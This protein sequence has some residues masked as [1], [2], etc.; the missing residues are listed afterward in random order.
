MSAMGLR[1][2][3]DDSP[4]SRVR[5]HDARSRD[6][7]LSDPRSIDPVVKPSTSRKGGPH[8]NDTEKSRQGHRH[9]TSNESSKA[10][11][12]TSSS[13]ER[14]QDRNNRDRDP[15][16]KY[17]GL[18]PLRSE[19]SLPYRDQPR[20]H[21]LEDE[22][23]LQAAGA[24]SLVLADRASTASDHSR[25]TG[26]DHRTNIEPNDSISV[27]IQGG[28]PPPGNP[29]ESLFPVEETHENIDPKRAC[30]QK[31]LREISATY[32]RHKE[33]ISRIW[34]E[35]MRSLEEKQRMQREEEVLLEREW[36][37]TADRTGYS[38]C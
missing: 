23:F 20:S 36:I 26:G 24:S 12:G 35:P 25:W 33:K 32:Q 6:S 13:G 18:V 1:R 17:A 37:A 5:K 11:G 2:P 14:H 4:L 21:N 38:V 3:E 8:R 27:A 31:F 28:H 7:S 16:K 29:G 34:A 22:L 30:Q 10:S 19:P 9:N 15:P